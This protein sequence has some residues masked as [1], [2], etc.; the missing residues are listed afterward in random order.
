MDGVLD[1]GID[2]ENE[3]LKSNSESSERSVALRNSVETRKSSLELANANMMTLLKEI[4]EYQS[5]LCTKNDLQT[6][7]LTI[8]KQFNLVDQRVSNNSSAI[9]SVKARLCSIES[10]LR[11]NDYEAELK[12]VVS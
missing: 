2:T 8:K 3:M 9:S 7:S 5:T 11:R 12:C 1:I 4:R 6:Y 10:Q